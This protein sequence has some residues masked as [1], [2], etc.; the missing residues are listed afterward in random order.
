MGVSADKLIIGVCLSLFVITG[1][2]LNEREHA[3]DSDEMV[4]K[5]ETSVVGLPNPFAKVNSIPEAEDA[6]GR[7]IPLLRFIPE[8]YQDSPDIFVMNESEMAQ[9]MYSSADGSERMLYRISEKFSTEL[10]N[11]DYTKYAIN[12][13]IIIR[14]HAVLVKGNGDG[15]GYFTA[16]WSVGGLNLCIL[17]DVPLTEEDLKRMIN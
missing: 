1:C 16:E 15:Q 6:I 13:K 2:H 17:S 10:L 11:G 4:I 5:E 3:S 12:K 7:N 14:G 9:L 8:V